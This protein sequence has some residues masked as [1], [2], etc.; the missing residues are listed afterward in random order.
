MG[1]Q[2]EQPTRMAVGRR[3]D[4]A[5]RPL[6]KGHRRGRK[7]GCRTGKRD[8]DRTLRNQ[9]GKTG[10]TRRG[11]KEDEVHSWPVCGQKCESL[12]GVAEP[13]NLSHGR[14]HASYINDSG[15]AHLTVE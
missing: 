2:T 8:T 7:G 12:M 15:N 1:G 10:E 14:K 4:T 13:L 5:D 3:V 11:R 6:G 9:T